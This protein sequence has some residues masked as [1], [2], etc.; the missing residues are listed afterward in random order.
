MISTA[1]RI[2][3]GIGIGEALIVQQAAI[4]QVRPG[5]CRR[6]DRVE[7]WKWHRLSGDGRFDVV[8]PLPDDLGKV[9]RILLRKPWGHLEEEHDCK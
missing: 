1:G 7:R 4:T 3:Q 8:E 2:V 5:T 6:F 9:T